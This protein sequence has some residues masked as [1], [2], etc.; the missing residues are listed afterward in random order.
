MPTGDPWPRISI[1]TPSY[2]QGGFIEETIR[3]VVLQGY[4]DLEYIIID[5]GSTDGSLEVIRRYERQLT[6]WM[7]EAD[8]G[9]SHAINKGLARATGEIVGWLN[10]D[11]LYLPGTL[12]RAAEAFKTHPDAGVIHGGCRRV[13]RQT[14]DAGQV[15]EITPFRLASHLVRNQIPQAAAFIRRTVIGTVGPVREDLHFAMDFELWIRIA[16]RFPIITVREDWAAFRVHPQQKTRAPSLVWADEMIRVYR[17]L[18]ASAPF[19]SEPL[20]D[21]LRQGLGEY[22]RAR[23]LLGMEGGHRL[24]G[25]RD[26]L[27]SSL[28]QR[29]KLWS[30]RFHLD[31]L[32]ALLKTVLPAPVCSFLRGKPASRRLSPGQ[33]SGHQ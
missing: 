17:E 14:E 10:S 2:N 27:W 16:L 13:T 25:T 22:L 24:S 5:G 20:R 11:D 7:T 28:Y 4:P 15:W 30:F 23:G 3:S 18:A 31:L 12:A 19:R 33:T 8:R 29:E 21:S 32:K 9:Q 1:V 26:Y 6:S